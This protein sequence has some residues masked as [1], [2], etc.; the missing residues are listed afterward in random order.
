MQTEPNLTRM[1][2][3]HRM[4]LMRHGLA[5]ALRAARPE[6]SIMQSADFPSAIEHCAST[7][8]SLALVDLDLPDLGGAP[9]IHRLRWAAPDCAVVVLA[10]TD[11]RAAVM[12]CLEAGAQGFISTAANS[13]QLFHALDTVLSGGVVAP[14][15]LVGSPRPEPKPKPVA[16]SA[17]QFSGRQRD[18]LC[19]LAEGCSTKAIARRLDLAVGTVKVHLAAIYRELG[20]HSRLEAVSRAFAV[21]SGE[22][23]MSW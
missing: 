6:W 14:K 16:P 11:E 21:S 13:L 20:V 19:L 10:E 5:S 23:E 22:G 8:P 3:A 17:E 1:V 9:G 18:V 4:E 7:Q 2:L 12:E 15:T